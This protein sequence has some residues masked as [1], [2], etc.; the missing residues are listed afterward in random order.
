MQL[1]L[2]LLESQPETGRKFALTILPDL[3]TTKTGTFCCFENPVYCPSG[4]LR[5]LAEA[6]VVAIREVA[7]TEVAAITLKIL[8]TERRG[9]GHPSWAS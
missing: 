8:I 7:I 2:G 1:Q 5:D 4:T 9:R 6:G 3:T